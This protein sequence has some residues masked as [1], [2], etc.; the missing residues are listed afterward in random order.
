MIISDKINKV[1]IDKCNVYD[2]KKFGIHLMG[3]DG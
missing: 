2:N 1:I 3:Q